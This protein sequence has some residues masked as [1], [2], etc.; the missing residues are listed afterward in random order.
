M[1]ALRRG[2][3]GNAVDA[4]DGEDKAQQAHRARELRAESVEEETVHALKR[5]IHR[6]QFRDGEIGS[7]RADLRLHLHG[8]IFWWNGSANMKRAKRYVGLTQRKIEVRRRR[9]DHASVFAI[10]NDT[11]H[12]EERPGSSLDTEAFS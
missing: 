5:L 11:D 4:D 7:E 3:R 8:E 1:G 2:V 9:F 10:L 12:L 6:L